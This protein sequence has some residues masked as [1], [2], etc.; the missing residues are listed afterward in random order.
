MY[1]LIF[2][3][4]HDF[5]LSKNDTGVFTRVKYWYDYAVEKRDVNHGNAANNY[6]PNDI[7]ETSDFHDLASPS[8]FE[9]L[10]Y[11]V[12]TSFEAGKMPIELRAGNMVLSWGE[13]TFIQNGL[14]VINPFDVSALR[15]PGTEIKEGLLP[16]GLVYANVGLTQDLS[17]EVFYQYQW[18]RTILDECGSYWSAS[19]PYGGGCNYLTATNT[20]P[21]VF[22][23][24][25][26]AATMFDFRVGRGADEEASDTG[27]WG[28]ALRYFAESLNAT[29]FGLYYMNL[30]SRTPIFSGINTE[31]NLGSNILFGTNPKYFFEFPEDI[32]LFGATFATNI[33][34]WAW[35]GEISHRPEYPLQINTVDL[36]QAIALGGVAEWSPM[37]TRSLTAGVGGHVRGYDE[38]KYTQVQ[39]TF[40]KF[41]EQVLGASRLS[42]AAEV[43]AAFVDDMDD[44][45][46]YGRSSAYGIGDFQEYTATFPLIAGATINCSTN[47]L[48]LVQPNTNA[49]YC[50]NDGFT[51][52]FSWGYRIRASLDY[53]DVIAGINLTPSIAWSHDVNGTSPAPNFIDGR[54]A[55]SLGLRADY[56]NT[57]R[58]DLSYTSFF[59]A[60]YNELQDRDFIAFS[61]SASF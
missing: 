45:I 61:F 2:K 11:Y 43:G 39:S 54:K 16:V 31:S 30:H 10:D 52:D 12:F 56:L 32:Q 27:Q 5:E 15:K 59:G 42:F 55:I 53:S 50:N 25:G 47:V 23:A 7:L 14:N 26:P 58:A 60:D 6:T 57:Y 19:D 33:G 24:I 8:G 34:D 40:I 46:N 51:D 29:E 13:S 28:I 35:S 1:S 36:L 37:L 22:Q 48:G 49:N 4:I 17:A 20:I 21:D 44:S 38:V 3:G 41:F 9:F 18:E